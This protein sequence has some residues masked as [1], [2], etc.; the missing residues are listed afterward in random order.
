MH[1]HPS[2]GLPEP[3]VSWTKDGQTLD[4]SD[5]TRDIRLVRAGRIVHI[6]SADV[7]HSGI[8]TCVAENK[9]GRDQRRYNLQVNGLHFIGLLQ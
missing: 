5:R 7:D 6:R 9:A 3:L 4:R 1:C 2:H 8:Y